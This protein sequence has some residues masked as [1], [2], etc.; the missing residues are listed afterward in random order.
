VTKVLCQRALAT[1]PSRK[2]AAA[3]AVVGSSEAGLVALQNCKV[4]GWMNE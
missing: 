2:F 1:T 4:A 3:C